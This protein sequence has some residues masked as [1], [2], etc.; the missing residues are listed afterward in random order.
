MMKR[1]ILTAGLMLL[2]SLAAAQT[3]PVT[4][5]DDFQSYGKSKKPDGWIDGKVG[6]L[7]AKPRGYYKTF[8][9]PT[10]DNKGTNLV[11]GTLKSLGDESDEIK[12]IRIGD[13]AT[14]T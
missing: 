13:F 1:L 4:Y 2:A 8:I 10:Q 9:D 12:N 11:F 14:Y 7:K 5:I 3:P 6:D